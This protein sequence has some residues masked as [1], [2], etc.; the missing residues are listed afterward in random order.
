MRRSR[1]RPSS[2]HTVGLE[3]KLVRLE[4][5][6]AIAFSSPSHPVG[7]EHLI[8]EYRIQADP[9][10][11]HTVGLELHH[12]RLQ[13]RLQEDAVTIPRGGLG[14]VE[15]GESEITLCEVSPSHTVGL[16]PKL[17][18]L[19]V[20]AGKSHYPT[21]WVQNNL[22]LSLET[23]LMLSPSH[24]VGLERT[25]SAYVWDYCISCLH[26]TQRAQ[27][28]TGTLVLKQSTSCLHPTQWA[29]NPTYTG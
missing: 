16:E 11:S 20:E 18:P 9:F 5:N 12:Q 19:P 15:I 2:S 1:D 24:P 13:K 22:K 27:N 3:L 7:L 23:E 29:R 26:P 4:P 25:I 21:Q 28:T 17:P 14:T 6:K 8:K 10:P